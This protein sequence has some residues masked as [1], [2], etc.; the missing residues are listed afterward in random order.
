[1]R[2]VELTGKAHA[3]QIK[4]QSSNPKDK[5]VDVLQADK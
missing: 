1:M 5:M 2:I 4:F 3:A